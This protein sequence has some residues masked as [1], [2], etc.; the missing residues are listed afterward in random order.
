MTSRHV[1]TFTAEARVFPTH[2]TVWH[3]QCR[4]ERLLL[5]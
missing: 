5:L 3:T 2:V 4:T 1:N